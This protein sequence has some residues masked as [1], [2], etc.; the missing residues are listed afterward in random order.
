MVDATAA[1]RAAA[2]V[3]TPLGDANNVASRNKPVVDFGKKYF[4]LDHA[5]TDAGMPD[6]DNAVSTFCVR[7]KGAQE[8]GFFLRN[9]K[10]VTLGELYDNY[11][12]DALWIDIYNAFLEGHVIYRKRVDAVGSMRGRAGRGGSK[13]WKQQG[14]ASHPWADTP[15]TW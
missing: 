6:F 13:K 7:G 10:V 14:W 8:A 9:V 2:F 4:V 12:Q 11:K 1:A 3:A 5:V 15:G